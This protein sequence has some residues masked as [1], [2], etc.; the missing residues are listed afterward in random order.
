MHAEDADKEEDVAL[1]HDSFERLGEM[2]PNA[3]VQSEPSLLQYFAACGLSSRVLDLAD[4]IFANDYAADMSDVGLHEVMHEQRHWAYGEKYLVLKGACLQDA[5]DTLARGLDVRTNWKAQC[6]RKLST[7]RIE[8][9]GSHGQSVVARGAIVTVPLPVLQRREL[10]FEPPL[11]SAHAGAIEKVKMGSALKVVVKL[12]RRF[13]PAD[14]YDAVCSDSFMPEVWLTP[15]AEAMR[16]DALPPYMMVGF[17]AGERA[18]R[19]AKLSHADIARKM[20]SQLDAMFGTPQDPHPA[21]GCC[22]GFL[23]KDWAVQP[24]TYGAYTH[25]SK[26]AAGQRPKLC[27]ALHGSIFF[28]GEACHTGVNPCI[29]GAMETGEVAALRCLEELNAQGVATSGVPRSRL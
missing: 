17:V 12:G 22:E 4:A 26:G 13:W 16:P 25:P 7:G 11:P 28:A 2:E 3:D 6:V 5:M 18:K 9:A 29:H 14:F 24:G 10:Q 20:L 15:A 1:M 21:S 23:V 8:V 19:V 27:E